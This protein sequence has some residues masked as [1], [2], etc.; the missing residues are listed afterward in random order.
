MAED[1]C[2]C[3]GIRVPTLGFM[4][5]YLA[6]STRIGIRVIFLMIYDSIVDDD[7]DATS[8]QRYPH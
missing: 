4:Y 3:L 1:L 8:S 6:I 2:H 5:L 7:K